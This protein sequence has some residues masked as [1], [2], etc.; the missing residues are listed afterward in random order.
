MTEGDREP[1]GRKPETK[2]NDDKV[3]FLST[4]LSSQ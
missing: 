2:K 3:G 1:A 4:R